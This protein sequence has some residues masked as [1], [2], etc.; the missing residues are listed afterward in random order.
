MKPLEHEACLLLGSNIEPE[1]NLP[2]TV[3]LLR[4]EMTVLRASSV[5]QTP[6][7][8]TAGPDFLNMTL[9]VSTPFEQQAL[10]E[11]VLRPLEARMGRVRSADKFAPR[12]IDLDIVVFDGKVVDPDLFTYAHRAV[13]VS[14]LLPNLRSEQGLSITAAATKLAQATPIHVK[15]GVFV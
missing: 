15:T 5:W 7:I 13:P 3:D 9:L 12:P 11:K 10:K 1:R 4:Q 6:P 8:G 14:E 2:R